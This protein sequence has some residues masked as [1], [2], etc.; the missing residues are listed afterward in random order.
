M[1][2]SFPGSAASTAV[3]LMIILQSIL[4][5]EVALL[6]ELQ[7][8]TEGHI[9]ESKGLIPTSNPFWS[10]LRLPIK[11]LKSSRLGLGLIVVISL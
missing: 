11:V 2:P 9:Q 7:S 8:L 3:T 10:T 4:L 1:M 6:E 5:K